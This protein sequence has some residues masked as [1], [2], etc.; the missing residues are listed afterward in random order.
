MTQNDLLWMQREKDILNDHDISIEDQNRTLSG[1]VPS[2]YYRD[3]KR[4]SSKAL[5]VSGQIEEEEEFSET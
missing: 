3:S 4:L 5:D 2:I 1:N